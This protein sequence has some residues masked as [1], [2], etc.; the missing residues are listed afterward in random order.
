ML[1]TRPVVLETL[2]CDPWGLRG[3]CG[4]YFSCF[5]EASSLLAS[6]AMSSS[7]P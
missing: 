5:Q 3:V 2:G 4:R 7:L 6:I 1:S